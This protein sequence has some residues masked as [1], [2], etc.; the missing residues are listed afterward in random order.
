MN[1]IQNEREAQLSLGK[2]AGIEA[3]RN[4]TDQQRTIIA[5]GMT[6]VEIIPGRCAYG[7]QVQHKEW[8]R[9]FALGLLDQARQAGRLVV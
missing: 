2:I 9:G 4:A 8:L 7:G 5:F 6:P 1:S 3:Y